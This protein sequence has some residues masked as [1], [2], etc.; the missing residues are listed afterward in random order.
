M[1]HGEAADAYAAAYAERP[2]QRLVIDVLRAGWAAG[3][4]DPPEPATDWLE[5]NPDDATVLKALAAWQIERGNLTVAKQHLERVLE[6]GQKDSVAMNDLA[7]VYQQTNDERALRTAERAYALLPENAAIADTLGWI[8]LEAGKIEP[9]LELLE[10]AGKAAPQNPE[11]QYHLAMA[12]R[13]SGDPDAAKRILMN[14]IQA[15]KNF[16]SREA[17][18]NVLTGL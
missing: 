7:W 17:A 12:Y 8:Q 15:D 5:L 9:A 11:I 2:G 16:P 14:L 6:L 1:R 4:D 10:K 18:E 3:L 13:E